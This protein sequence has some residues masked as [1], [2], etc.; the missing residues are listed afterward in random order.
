MKS[1]TPPCLLLSN[2][3]CGRLLCKAMALRTSSCG[4]A[5]SNHLF[6]SHRDRAHI[7][8]MSTGRRPTGLFPTHPTGQLTTATLLPGT[9]ALTHHVHGTICT[10]MPQHSC[11]CRPKQPPSPLP[12]LPASLGAGGNMAHTHPTSTRLESCS[13]HASCK[14][15]ACKQTTCLTGPVVMH[16]D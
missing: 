10:H 5:C 11:S 14:Q 7:P 2:L 12:P 15:T 8:L 3:P 1:H 13:P 6:Q 9:C 16:S 4:I